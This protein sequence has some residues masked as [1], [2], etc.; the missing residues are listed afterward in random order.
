MQELKQKK[1]Y[2]NNNKNVGK[3]ETLPVDLEKQE[4]KK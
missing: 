4:K 2:K 1:N 3:S